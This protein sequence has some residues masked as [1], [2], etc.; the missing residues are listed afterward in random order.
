MKRSLD[1]NNMTSGMFRRFT[2]IEL[3]VVIAIIAILAAMLL[4][5]LNRARET[6]RSI[7]CMS[8]MKTLTLSTIL[9]TDNYNGTMMPFTFN[10][11]NG[12]V[13]PWCVTLAGTQKLE[14]NV[15]SCPSFPDPAVNPKDIRSATLANFQNW[16]SSSTQV[17]NY[18]HYGINI[19][20]TSG[21]PIKGRLSMALK[22]SSKILY[23]ENFCQALKKY[24][25]YYLNAVFA[26]SGYVGILDPRHSGC[27][28]IAFGDGHA[29]AFKV[30]S[31]VSKYAF[32]DT[33]NPY[34]STPFNTYDNWRPER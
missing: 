26:S 1:S 23:G 18:P 11:A 16:N 30:K 12:I 29:A 33:V 19:F 22:P 34:L 32:A 17:M 25:Y 10:N 31:N 28:N 2:L 13:I 9:Y 27:V 5:A 15:F 24:G 14:G 21:Y 7:S 3:L 4:P 6:A 8:Q 20:Y